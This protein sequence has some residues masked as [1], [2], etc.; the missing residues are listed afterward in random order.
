MPHHVIER[1]VLPNCACS[2][3]HFVYRVG[4]RSFDGSDNFLK[5]KGSLF[6]ILKRH[7]N[8]VHM[9]WHY[10]RNIEPHSSAI[11]IKTM[12]Q[13]DIARCWRQLPSQ[14][15]IECDEVGPA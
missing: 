2:L 8:H 10:Y 7:K 12:F 9:V 6:L 1:F 11:V 4:R 13:D 3:Q 15:S 14:V 5:G